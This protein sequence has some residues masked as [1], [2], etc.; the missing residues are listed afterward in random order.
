MDSHAR[1]LKWKEAPR[2]VG[3]HVVI[4][5]MRHAHVP[6]LQAA[7]AGDALARCWYTS[8]P[9]VARVEAWVADAL[10]AQVRGG[11]QPFVVLDHQ[12]RACGSTRYYDMQ[13]EVPRL[14]IGHTWYAPAVQRTAVNTETKLLLLAHAFEGLGCIRVEFKTSACNQASRAALAR[15]GARQE[16]V[17]RNDSRHADASPRD[18]VVFSI[19]DIEWPQVKQNLGQKLDQRAGNN[20]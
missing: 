1:A 7:L 2:F 3:R 13:A 17:L 14:S 11:A 6:G 8:V 5:P 4:E 16:G 9:T 20:G 10:Q 18:S 15:L 12:G 19:I